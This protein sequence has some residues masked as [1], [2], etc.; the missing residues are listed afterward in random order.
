MRERYKKNGL[1]SF[2]PHEVLEL[3]LFYA[4]P[5]RN[6]NDIAKNL[7]DHF[8]GL[9]DVFE[10][11][12]EALIDAGLTENQAL[13]LKLIPDVTRV[14]YRDRYERDD[15]PL[16]YENLPDLILPKYIGLGSEERILL[17]LCDT[18][19]KQCFCGF[20]SEGNF[21]NA[22]LSIRKIV[23]LAVN[24]GATTAFLAHNHPSGVALPSADDVKATREIRSALA[25]VDV[26]LLDHFIVAN[27]ECISMAQ[28]NFF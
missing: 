14:Y 8:G 22:S 9:S 23:R 19:G 3:L 17:I 4:V 16:D 10:A 6:T 12:Y 20:I 11:P 28:S 15:G 13:F 1:E 2:S 21:E 25:M 26:S 27:G 18:K 24:C 5:Y 7:I